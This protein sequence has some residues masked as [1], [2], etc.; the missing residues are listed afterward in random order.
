MFAALWL[1]FKYKTKLTIYSLTC[2]F[3]SN[4]YEQF[5]L[6]LIFQEKN[7]YQEPFLFI[8]WKISITQPIGE[9]IQ[10]DNES[11]VAQSCDYNIHF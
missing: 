5:F 3:L 9:T 2:G 1:E 6:W 11:E 8:S 10:L 7:A 4:I